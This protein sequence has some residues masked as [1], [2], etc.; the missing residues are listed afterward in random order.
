M[1]KSMGMAVLVA[2]ITLDPAPNRMQP[3]CQQI[4]HIWLFGGAVLFRTMLDAGLVD[5]VELAVSPVLLGSGVPVLPLGQRCPSSLVGS[6]TLPN[7]ILNLIFD[8][9]F[10]R[11]C[12]C[13]A[14]PSPHFCH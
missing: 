3:S 7:G 12:C 13:A 11:R 2:S 8:V 4:L 6:T 9:I 10:R 5:Q 14:S 1:L